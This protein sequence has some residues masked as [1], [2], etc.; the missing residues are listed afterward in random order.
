M[1]TAG[2]TKA[3]SSAGY[4]DIKVNTIVDKKKTTIPTSLVW[5]VL[6]AFWSLFFAIL[7]TPAS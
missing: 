4:Q 3:E 7:S 2:K 6:N 5:E 1:A